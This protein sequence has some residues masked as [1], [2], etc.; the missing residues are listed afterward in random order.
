M[1]QSDKKWLSISESRQYHA[2]SSCCY[3][4]H[5]MIT[6]VVKC[7]A[8]F[9]CKEIAMIRY[10]FFR[11]HYSTKKN[12][13]P[14]DIILMFPLPRQRSNATGHQNFGAVGGT[15]NNVVGVRIFFLCYNGASEPI[16]CA[17]MVPQSP[18]GLISAEI[19][20]LCCI[21]GEAKLHS[22]LFLFS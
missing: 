20:A 5:N 16:F 12:S 19:R 7:N 1:L 11:V 21:S 6:H 14:S 3:I 2:W 9:S 8:H 4:L 10:G 17:I 13:N 18:I 22:C 15:S